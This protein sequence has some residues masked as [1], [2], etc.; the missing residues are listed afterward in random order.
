MH[1]WHTATLG[2]ICALALTIEPALAARNAKPVAGAARGWLSPAAAQAT[3]LL[4]VADV[5]DNAVLI[6]D[7]N[8]HNPAP[9]GSITSGIDEPDGLTIDAAGTLFV[10][11]A[12]NN[13]VTTYR[14]GSLVVA[15]TYRQ[16]LSGP[17]D[18]AVGSDG[19]LYV[20][21][22]HSGTDGFVLEYPPHGFSP[23][24]TI[25]DFPHRGVPNDV[26]LDRSGNLYVSYGV[27]GPGV[28]SHVNEYAP[29]SSTPEP[30]GM[31]FDFAAGMTFDASGDLLV[32]D[33]PYQAVEV[34]KP[35]HRN[36]FEDIT[37]GFGEPV[38][39]AFN[40]RHDR[41]YVSDVTGKAVHVFAYP[42]AHPIGKISNG[43]TQPLGIALFAKS[44]AGS[45]R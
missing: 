5:A 38:M 18:V 27:R 4:Y 2:S 39:P 13:T 44:V 35:R 28:F 42:S 19:T 15:N 24:R 25:A 23:N 21:N 6:Y 26:A 31:I 11:N 29:H 32:C 1:A 43:F 8:A 40:A 3:E 34:F 12:G 33:E 14:H 7:A 37:A 22:N 9:L 10:A 16:G 17:T 36:P 45:I 20:S 41:L 30:L